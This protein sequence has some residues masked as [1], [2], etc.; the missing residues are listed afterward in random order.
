MHSGLLTWA[1]WTNRE[2]VVELE[3]C[4]AEIGRLGASSIGEKRS[5]PLSCEKVIVG[6]WYQT[7]GCCVGYFRKLKWSRSCN[8]RSYCKCILHRRT[9]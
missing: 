5:K 1:V 4:V 3:G 9:H 2:G 6:Y 7:N 8:A